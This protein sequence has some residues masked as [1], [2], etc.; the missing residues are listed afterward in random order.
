MRA[1]LE[2]KQVFASD[3]NEWYSLLDMISRKDASEETNKTMTESNMLPK[4]LVDLFVEECARLGGLH[5][6]GLDIIV[7]EET[8]DFYLIDLNDL[9]SY[10]GVTGMNDALLKLYNQFRQ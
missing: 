7:E 3:E 2:S 4:E 1:S 9:P 8:L 5:C 10:N 6:Y